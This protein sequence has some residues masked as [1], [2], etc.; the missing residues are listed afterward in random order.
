MAKL[1]RINISETE[2]EKFSQDLSGILDNFKDL[3]QLDVSQVQP[4]N[5]LAVEENQLRKDQA[6]ENQEDEKEK[7]RKQFPDRKDNYLKVKAVL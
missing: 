1:A 5:F 3:N 2:Q 4:V 7:I 6:R